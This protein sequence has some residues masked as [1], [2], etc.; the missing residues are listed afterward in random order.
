MA[1][2]SVPIHVVV[3]YPQT[4]EGQRDLSARAAGV[5]ADMVAQYIQK[6]NCPVEQKQR[7]LDAVIAAAQEQA[8]APPDPPLSG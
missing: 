5:H 1:K 6:L 7:L 4:Q 3:H 2:T 8:A